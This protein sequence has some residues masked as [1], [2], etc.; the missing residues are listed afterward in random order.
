[1]VVRDG[2]GDDDVHLI[3]MSMTIHVRPNILMGFWTSL[4]SNIIYSHE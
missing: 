4:I 3:T 1:M 2:K